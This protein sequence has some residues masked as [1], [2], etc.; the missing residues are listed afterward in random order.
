[1]IAEEGMVEEGDLVKEEDTQEVVQLDMLEEVEDMVQEDKRNSVVTPGVV[2][3]VLLTLVHLLT[4]IIKV[5]RSICSLLTAWHYSQCLQRYIILCYN[6]H[7]D[8]NRT[9]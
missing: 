5:L 1:M 9:P 7:R 6:S 3:T 2:T 4:I 8:Y